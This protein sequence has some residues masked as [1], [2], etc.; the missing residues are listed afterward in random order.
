MPI[1]LP[2][3]SLL[4]SDIAEMPLTLLPPLRALFEPL[5]LEVMAAA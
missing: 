4:A 5:L 2:P 1:I 3:S